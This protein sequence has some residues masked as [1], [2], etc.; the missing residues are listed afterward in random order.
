MAA[1]YDV[2]QYDFI[3]FSPSAAVTCGTEENRRIAF[4][5][6]VRKVGALLD[7]AR[8]LSIARGLLLEY[9]DKEAREQLE[10]ICDKDSGADAQRIALTALRDKFPSGV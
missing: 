1:Q 6:T 10:K 9:A 5:G 8:H 2:A 3:R 7:Q 4:E